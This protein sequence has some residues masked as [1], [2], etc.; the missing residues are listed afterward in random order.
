MRNNQNLPNRRIDSNN[1]NEQQLPTTSPVYSNSRSRTP[2]RSQS[3]NGYYN[4]SDRRDNH[5]YQRSRNT[6]EVRVIGVQAST[7]I[8]TTEIEITATTEII[9]I[10]KPIIADQFLDIQ[11]IV[12]PDKIHHTTKMI[13]IITLII[14]INTTD[15]D[16]AAEIPAELIYI[17]K[18]Q[19]VTID[20]TQ[21]IIT[22]TIEE[23]HRIENK[24]TVIIQ[25]TKVKKETIITNTI[26]V[27]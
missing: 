26:R 22:E 14:I 18:D 21:T 17:D 10:K 7:E 4:R 25:G 13:T 16:N 5:N 9:I 24:K 15:K 8:T 12:I 2:Y 6:T 1:I 11:T 3:R 27:E 19:R 20:N 23:V